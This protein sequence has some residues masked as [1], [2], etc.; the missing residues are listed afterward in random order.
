[1]ILIFKSNTTIIVFITYYI[2]LY[3]ILSIIKQHLWYNPI[4]E[5]IIQSDN[6]AILQQD[7]GS[8]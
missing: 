3:R 4:K 5:Y 8:L 6:S 1:M 7:T 2:T